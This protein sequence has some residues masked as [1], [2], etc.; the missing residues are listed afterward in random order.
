MA[1]LRELKKRI[2]TVK[3]TA[4]F[5]LFLLAACSTYG[6]DGNR[7]GFV[8]GGGLGLSPYSKWS[9]YGT[10]GATQVVEHKNENGAGPGLNFLIGHAWN[11]QNMIVFEINGASWNSKELSDN[12]RVAQGTNGT[13][14]YHYFGSPGR[15]VFSAA[16]LVF[17]RF[18]YWTTSRF[19][20]NMGL[21]LIFGGGYEFA[22]HW[23]IGGYLGTGHSYVVSSDWNYT[24]LNILVSA[25][26]F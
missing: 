9:G 25:I 17:Y 6:F 1:T 8:L 26:L 4:L 3:F 5:A 18:T 24:H 2:R 12:P 11:E 7:K 14:W 23:Q 15:S 19:N 20:Q 13:V 21:G 22:R 10:F 16:G